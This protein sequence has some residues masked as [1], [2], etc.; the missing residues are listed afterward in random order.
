MF[1]FNFNFNYIAI[2][3]DIVDS[4]K[5]ANR[6]EV[7]SKYKEAIENINKKYNEDI[8]AKFSISLG[9][10]FQGLLKTGENVINIITDIELALH[11]VKI[12]FG[13]GVG[14]V[15]TNINKESTFEVDGSAYHRA[16]KMI[17]SIEDKKNRN[18]ESYSN[19]LISS[20]DD[21]VD[22][23]ELL[24]TILSVSSALKS[25][26]TDR[27][28]E[29]ISAYLE[30]EKNQYQTASALNISQPSVYKSLNKSR[31]YTYEAAMDKVSEYL[32]RKAESLE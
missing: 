32:S 19:I 10:E 22:I 18:T 17:G 2:I 29:I 8:E 26:W 1:V 7:Q 11:P 21:K 25:K 16:R 5:I 13:I 3:G 20:S 4:K 15:N 24:N 6:N 12:R 9:D 14:D 28:I 30:N 31:Y 27:Q 23:D